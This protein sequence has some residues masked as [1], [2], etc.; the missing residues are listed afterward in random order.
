M[1]GI[2]ASIKHMIRFFRVASNPDFQIEKNKCSCV[3][4]LVFSIKLSV[5]SKATCTYLNPSIGTLE[6]F[7][8]N[9]DDQVFYP[10]PRD[11]QAAA[12]PLELQPQSC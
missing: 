4:L 1:C 7:F 3:V 6:V 11:W 9:T 10:Q 5:Q 2:L 12:L 8:L